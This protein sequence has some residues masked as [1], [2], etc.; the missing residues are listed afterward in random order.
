MVRVRAK[1][2]KDDLCG[3]PLFRVKAKIDNDILFG[4]RGKIEKDDLCGR[5]LPRVRVTIEKHPSWL[6]SAKRK[7]TPFV[8]DL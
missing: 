8:V 6:D 4:W 3:M 1:I 7:K 2:E 5:P